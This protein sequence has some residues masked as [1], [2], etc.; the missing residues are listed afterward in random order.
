MGNK[1][2]AVSLDHI[3]EVKTIIE[4]ELIESVVFY[5]NSVFDKLGMNVITDIENAD[6][7]YQFMGKNG[8][9]QVYEA[10]NLTANPLGYL[11]A[12]KLEVTLAARLIAD[13]VQ[14]YREKEPW[15]LGKFNET[16]EPTNTE[17][18]MRK[19]ME[20]YRGDVLAPMFFGNPSLGKKHPLGLY[21]G[22]NTIIDELIN[23]GEISE[24]KLN[25]TQLEAPFVAPAQVGDL[26]EAF[27]AWVESWDA[28]LRE[29]ERVLVYLPSITKRQLISDYMQKFTGFQS[30]GSNSSAFRMEPYENIELISD[31]RMGN[32][33]GEVGAR[34]IATIPG[35][36]DFGC[37]TESDDAKVGIIQPEAD[38]NVFYYQIQTAQGMRIRNTESEAFNVSS[39]LNHSVLV[40]N[41]Q[42]TD[43][44]ISVS[45]N[46]K[47]MGS[48]VVDPVK[49]S[50]AKGE[51][52]TLTATAAEGHKFV[53]WSDNATNNPRTIIASGFPESYQAIFEKNA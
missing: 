9:T 33:D 17:F 25:Y 5:D 46:D 36:I 29:A 26:Y 20:I 37:D 11:K 50:Y 21:K 14:N 45:V 27:V 40:G 47:T 2:R 3:K 18:I 48:A 6:V 38:I 49:T 16:H 35:N 39:G 24:G 32:P 28:K 30:K 13:N 31:P 8:A 10:G 44:T 52:V 4:R 15:T 7:A 42:Y 23:S 53:K 43:E 34:L 1:L 22:V 19:T 41:G 12:R 51:S